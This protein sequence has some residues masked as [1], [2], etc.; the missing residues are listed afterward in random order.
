[1]ALIDFHFLSLSEFRNKDT[2]CCGTGILNAEGPCNARA[3]LCP[4]RR[5]YLFWDLF[6]PTMKAARLAA[7]TLYYGPTLYVSPINFSQLVNDS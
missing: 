1:M 5:K 7:E 6:H 3:S 2:A 4:N